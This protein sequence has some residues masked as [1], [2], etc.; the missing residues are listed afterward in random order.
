MRS[1]IKPRFYLTRT[2]VLLLLMLLLLAC[3]SIQLVDRLHGLYETQDMSQTQSQ[4]TLA[5]S[6]VNE[7]INTRHKALNSAA[8]F[9]DN[10]DV[11]REELLRQVE[12]KL[13][14]IAMRNY[15]DLTFSH[16]DVYDAEGHSICDGHSAGNEKFFE[17]AIRGFCTTSDIRNRDGKREISLAA[18]IYLGAQVI[19]A[20]DAAISLDDA[21]RLLEDINITYS[22]ASIFLVDANNMIIAA[23]SRYEPQ[24]NVKSVVGAPV[25]PVVGKLIGSADHEKFHIMYRNWND[26]TDNLNF[27]G[28]ESGRFA[29]FA[30][31]GNSE[32]W[33]IAAVS[34]LNSARAEQQ[35]MMKLLTWLFFGLVGLIITITLITYYFAFRATRIQHI[36]TLLL[37]SS[38]LFLMR[39][40]RH[41][42]VFEPG[43]KLCSILGVPRSLKTF[44][45][46]KLMGAKQDIFPL[47]DAGQGQFFTTRCLRT[48]GSE[49][50]LRVH[51]LEA[52]PD[53]VMLGL[54]IDTTKEETLRRRV[55][56][57]AYINQLTKLPNSE[58][59]RQMIS[60]AD[61]RGR[62]RG[63]VYNGV[64]CFISITDGRKILEVLGSEVYNSVLIEAAKRLGEVSAR[65]S[66]ELYSL[67]FADF[68]LYYEYKS[69]DEI[70]P[71]AEEIRRSIS[72]PAF[73]T[74]GV[75]IDI[76]ASVGV[77]THHEYIKFTSTSER[78]IMRTGE[79][80]LR[81]A[82]QNGGNFILSSA[83][84]S[85]ALR[86]L[87][88]EMDIRNAFQR[89]EIYL[90][91]Q[92]VYGVLEDKIVAVEAL[93]RWEHPKYGNVPPDVFIRIAENN[94]SI[95]ALGDWVADR[96]IE[97]AGKLSKLGVSVEFNVS[98]VQ[99]AQSNFAVKLAAK[100]RAAGLPPHSLGVEI[101]ESNGLSDAAKTS[102]I[103]RPIKEA[104]AAVYIDDF[105][106][107]YSSLSYLKDI[108]A[109]YVKLDK[110][111]VRDI[112]RSKKQRDIVRAVLVLSRAVGRT[113]II[114][115]VEQEDELE[116]LLSIGCRYIQGFL[117]A[118]PMKEAELYKF[119]S[120]FS[121]DEM[122]SDGQSKG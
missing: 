61:D 42:L 75:S 116:V 47:D 79:M 103:L 91:Y 74:E 2:F 14:K 16:I 86:E 18:P 21:G 112:A 29:S 28:A 34:S 37:D 93:A 6:I 122:S 35:R 22:G 62:R 100:I 27:N 48:D 13:S 50:F 72:E 1:A 33:R 7:R 30:K 5:A 107:G 23:A 3:L 94:G 59:F 4:V 105:G 80:A 81:L 90:V 64:C 110:S 111:F 70:A 60:S 45:I 102:V 15:D 43:E 57:L 25:C 46:T 71:L 119:L 24:L 106:T 55:S 84:Y 99:L 12:H 40:S 78:D 8:R 104:G 58:S 67:D 19:G 65:H 88:L 53:G 98:V 9:D 83:S 44:D 82:E 73:E 56:D 115:G 108:D 68:V 11:P 117:I 36:S 10:S 63:V 95:N 51:I 31:L 87:D 49:L 101:T 118:R 76:T 92:P 54:V 20:V 38:G 113:V 97:M 89:G 109:D 114:E 66:G 26:P 121:G 96:S 17:R 41:G 85:E 69:E 77:I 120:E 39:F 32:G 52:E